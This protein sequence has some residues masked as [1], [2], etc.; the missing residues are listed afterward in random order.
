MD[1]PKRILLIQLKRAGDVLVTTPVLP[2]L[3][4]A[5][6]DAWIDFLVDAPWAPLL[7]HNPNLNGVQTFEGAAWRTWRR[8]RAASYDW[9]IDF[10]SSPR[11]VIAGLY[12]GARRRVGYRVPFWGRWFHHS[13]RRP[14]REV[15]VTEG[16][17]ALVRSILA[18]IGPAGD[19]RV[20]LTGPE[21]AWAKEQIDGSAKRTI[22]LIPTHRHP[23]RRW[24]GESFAG[25]AR[26]LVS[27]GV[28]VWWFWGPGE[29]EYVEGFQRQVPG[30]HL[31]PS[32]SL[33]QMAALLEQCRGVVTNDNGPMHLAVAVGTPTITMY[34]PTDP[35]SWNPGGDPHRVVQAKGVSCLRCNL[36]ECPFGHECMTRISPDEVYELCRLLL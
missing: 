35:E 29:K 22:G 26:R 8:L 4:Q 6:P 3:R 36:N 23:V 9:I 28:A 13:I 34:G 16:K 30:S 17:M 10:Q 11:S 14:G 27:Q 18:D 25:V 33:R 20:F 5:L 21:R 15:S 24:P 32:A 7:E 1:K 31:I 19:H 2:A 12:S